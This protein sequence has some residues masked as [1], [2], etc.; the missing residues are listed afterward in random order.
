MLKSEILLSAFGVAVAVLLRCSTSLHS[1]SG[2]GKPPMFGDYEAQRHWMEITVNL[3]VQD[4]YHNTS[5]NDL[6]YWGLDYPP[7][8]AYH[9]YV[10]GLIADKINPSYVELTH[11]RGY[12][13][14]DHKLFMRYTVLFVDVLLFLPAVILYFNKVKTSTTPLFGIIVTV[15]YPGLILIDHGH[16]Q[17]NCVSLA[18]ALYAIT[19]I[20]LQKNVLA[21]VF[22]SLALN[23]KQMELYHSLP[24][25]IYL[26]STCVPKPGQGSSVGV[27]KLFNISL[28]VIVTFAIIWSPFLDNLNN[29]KQV[30][31]RLFPV[32]RGVFEDKVANI[33]CALNVLYKFKALGNTQMF[34]LCT[35]TT[36]VAVLPTS[37][38]LFLRPNVKKFTL[39]LINSSLA[40][41]LFSF[42]VHEKTILLVAL[43]VMLY[44]PIDPLTC[45]WFLFVSVF[46]MLPLFIKDNLIIAFISL[47]VFYVIIFHLAWEYTSAKGRSYKEVID[48]S[49]GCGG[50]F[51][52]IIVS[53]KFEGKPLLSRHRIVNNV[54]QEELA[55][56]SKWAYS[57]EKICHGKPSGI[58][59]TVCTYGSMVE[60]RKSHGVQFFSTSE[61][62]LLL[63]N[64]KQP[65]STK[66]LVG[67]VVVL[68][69]NH[70]LVVELILNTM[71]EIAKNAL[72]RILEV[73]KSDTENLKEHYD[74][75]GELTNM[76][77]CMLQALGVSH[78]KLDEICGIL[79]S[80]GLFGKLTGAGGGGYA[81]SIIPP[82][83]K[84]E[85]VRRLTSLTCIFYLYFG[86][87]R[88]VELKPFSIN[89]ETDLTVG[90]G[91]GSSASFAVTLAGAFIYYLRLQ[92]NNNS[93]PT[94]NEEELAIISKWAYSVEKIC[95]GKPSGIDNT[96][97]TYGSMVEFRKSH[98]VQFFSTSE[99]ELLLINTKQPRSTKQLVGNVV[100]LKENHNL[101]VEL[102]LNTMDEIAKN[103][104]GRILE[105]SKS[106]TENLKEH[107][108]RLGE[109]TNMN[110]CMLQA[111][112]VS[113]PK[114][115]EICGILKSV[116]L[117]GKLTG[118]GGGGY[119]ISIIPPY[120]KVETVRRVIEE[121][122]S[123]GYDTIL[124]ILVTASQSD[125]KY[126]YDIVTVVLLTEFLKLIT[127][128]T[129]YCRDQSITSLIRESI[130]S[131]RVLFL[132]FVP[133][134]LYCLYNNLAFVNLATFDP[135]T[136]YLLLQF[137]VVITALLF[138]T[139]FQKNLSKKQWFSLILL[140]CGC[141]LKGWNFTNTD[142][143]DLNQPSKLSSI[144]FDINTI[145]IFVQLVCS[146][147]AGVYN[148]YL[149]KETGAN[150][151]IFV[152]NVFM[153]LDSI[154][155]NVALLIFQGN[156]TAFALENVKK[157]F[158]YKVILVM[159]NNTAA[160]IV[161]SF[162][163]KNMNS[164]LK[165]FAAALELIFSATF[166]Y[167]L[168]NIPIYLNTVLAISLVMYSIYLYSQNP[169]SNPPKQMTH[170][171]DEKE[172]LMEEV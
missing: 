21:S 98:G 84:V 127:S 93:V 106:D 86:I 33:W 129:L 32:A 101:V 68:K 79:K 116:G 1:Y 154:V 121:L 160:G 77:Q 64:T 148:E 89:I 37:L 78:P 134:F 165:T 147:L 119:A 5:K 168:F 4:W 28:S 149:L 166:S 110:Q 29:A 80:V 35:V 43:P 157:V 136:Y 124:S 36:L 158:H 132:Y 59:N 20:Y 24:F 162:F 152:Q 51:S 97:C 130:A 151:N 54:L 57:V 171:D 120:T 113:H 111:L 15:F 30:L 85:T 41:F 18:L 163:L 42:Q 122:N 83:I 48:E 17:Y 125:N 135:T 49:D 38:D 65:R 71:D 103:A 104:L 146:C 115:D 66:Q 161:T 109:L 39:A 53:E 31:H 164:I 128:V 139:I 50:K 142:V 143:K 117:F 44:L 6:Q 102:I 144:S 55:I 19:F 150:T 88:T 34:R 70:N 90:A 11:S 3:P 27:R 45:F 58:D 123:K 52:C 60:F 75:L 118:A 170:R 81:I 155:C 63:I 108:D 138:Q 91:T 14:E 69:E 46:S 62:E 100:V 82:Y 67:N 26:L 73:S 96:V 167:F 76:N 141:M 95:H 169:V 131:K 12:E 159:L 61:L 140:T 22:F 9:S 126:E 10:C 145:L 25:F 47:M 105:V 153:Y 133:A 112:G 56:I 92:T 2:Q 13:G 99:L 23:Y 137:R 107:Y 87:L 172:L 72:A 94:F 74:R 16:F 7:L 8:T 156:F 114:L 40:F